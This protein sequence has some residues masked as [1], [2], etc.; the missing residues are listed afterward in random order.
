MNRGP[1]NPRVVGLSPSS[2]GPLCTDAA[3]G[4]GLITVAATTSGLAADLGVDSNACVRPPSRDETQRQ[5]ASRGEFAPFE[6][7]DPRKPIDD[8]R[9][10]GVDAGSSV[11]SRSLRPTRWACISER[12]R[13]TPGRRRYGELGGNGKI[14]VL[15]FSMQQFWRWLDP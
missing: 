12:T 1:S 7:Y 15:R 14:T 4:L 8:E 10:V 13:I 2:A 3:A 11:T 6:T 5:V 9:W